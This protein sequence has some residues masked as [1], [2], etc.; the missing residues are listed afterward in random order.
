MY[1]TAIVVLYNPDGNIF[2][3]IES[4]ILQ[5]NELII[6]VNKCDDYI[7]KQMSQKEV[8]IIQNKNNVGLSKALNLGIGLALKNQNCSHILLFDQD[9]K[10]QKE[11]VSNIKNV[12]CELNNSNV[13]VGAIG[14]NINDIKKNKTTGI[15]TKKYSVVD[16]IITSGSLIPVN[17][18]QEIGLMDETFFIDYIDYEWCFRASSKGY[19]LVIAHDALLDHNLGDNLISFIGFKKPIHNNAMRQYYIIRNQLIMLTRSYIPL[20]WRFKE[21][22]K[23]FY[24]IPGYIYF[25]VHRKQTFLNICKAILDFIKSYKRNKIYKY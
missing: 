8:T 10:P 6:V 22:M 17:S 12:Y 9:S 14:G 13:K 15:D 20:T 3:N 19:E 7:L 11:Y 21:F 24:R 2:D 25:S 23:L 18:I 5:V 4:I 16:V 1:V